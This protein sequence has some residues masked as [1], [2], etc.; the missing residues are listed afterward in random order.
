MIFILIKN[1]PKNMSSYGDELFAKDVHCEKAEISGSA[2]VAALDVS[3]AMNVAGKATAAEVVATKFCMGGVTTAVG[4]S[5][6][7]TPNAPAAGTPTRELVAGTGTVTIANNNT[8]LRF[9]I[10]DLQAAG[11]LG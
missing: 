9:L 1:K 7:Y 11:I 5:T 8:V 2:V 10:Q 6:A 4:S 3:G